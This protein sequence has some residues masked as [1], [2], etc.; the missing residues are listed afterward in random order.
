MAFRHALGIVGVIVVVAVAA[1]VGDD[2]TPGGG[3]SGDGGVGGEGGNPPPG[4]CDRACTGLCEACDVPGKEGICSPVTGKPRNG[5]CDGDTS[6]PCA[7]SCDG[8]NG[9]ACTYPTAACGANSCAGGTATVAPVCNKGTCGTPTTQT[10]SLGCFG[11][12]CLGIVSL[13][14]GYY[15]ACAALADKKVRCWGGNSSGQIGQGLGDVTPLYKTPKEVPGL[16][17]VEQVA[18]TFGTACARISDGTVKCWG[19]NSSGELGN[20]TAPDAASHPVPTVVTGLSG[21]TFIS[22]S[23]GGHFCAIGGG[24]GI[25]CWGSNSGG[26]LGNGTVT[27]TTSST[28]VIVCAPGSTTL[29]CTAAAG[30]TFVAGGDNHTCAAFAGGQVACWGGNEDAQLGLPADQAKH[31]FA[32]NLAGLDAKYLSAGNRV[33]CA[34]TLAGSAVCWGNNGA[35]RLGN[36]TDNQNQVTPVEVCT[37]QDCSTKMTGATGISNFDVSTC[38]L[39]GGAVSCWGD[40]TGGQ[41]GDG[42]ATA[43]QNFAGSIAIAKGGQLVVSG[44]QTNYAVV[45]DG[46]NRDVK[47]W[48]DDGNAQCGDNPAAGANIHKTPVSPLW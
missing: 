13:A 30:A 27:P 21:V 2:P 7:G 29:P 16:V 26:E 24:G 5:T 3:T 20:G 32:A 22:G 47:C 41:L 19:S 36:G 39:A 4:S 45:A 40:N 8:T 25:K 44:G 14:A 48:G 28:P 6:G 43:S 46:A 34:V 1:C 15:F 33:S 31:P 42:N 9:A 12:G 17:N 23:S 35:T 38:A 11:D 18:A 37:K 10:C